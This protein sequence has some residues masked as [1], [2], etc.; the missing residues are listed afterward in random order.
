MKI[1]RHRID[2]AYEWRQLLGAVRRF[3]AAVATRRQLLLV[4]SL[5]V[6]SVLAIVVLHLADGRHVRGP[7]HTYGNGLFSVVEERGVQGFVQFSIPKPFKAELERRG[8]GRLL[9]A[10]QKSTLN[11]N[12]GVQV[13]QHVNVF[14][15]SHQLGRLPMS[16][17]RAY[18]RFL[19]KHAPDT[20]SYHVQRLSPIGGHPALA[21]KSRTRD[22]GGYYSMGIVVCAH[23]RAYYYERYSCWSPYRDWQNDQQT[24]HFTQAGGLPTNFTVDDMDRVQLRLFVRAVLL[25]VCFVAAWAAMLHM[26]KVS[27]RRSHSGPLEIVNVR[28]WRRYQVLIASSII[29]RIVMLLIV[30][31]LCVYNG[32][33][34]LQCV[35]LVLCALEELC[36]ALPLRAHLYRKA[37]TT[38]PA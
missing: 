28:S 19:R 21:Y 24:Y 30:M 27:F 5:A 2:W 31:S 17:S 34:T 11:E 20:A 15:I 38:P 33:A 12:T 35:A 36:L 13:I 6:M 29:V 3:F 9:G 7:W 32:S 22:A 18:E 10:F 8:G 23:E 26:A 25:L 1:L 4:M 16:H 37:H 14:D